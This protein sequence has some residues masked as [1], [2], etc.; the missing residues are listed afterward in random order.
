MANEDIKAQP[1]FKERETEVDTLE[2]AEK[3]GIQIAKI[4]KI[5]KE[6]NS[7]P[8]DPAQNFLHDY[9][10]AHK[11]RP[12]YCAF[13]ATDLR[14]FTQLSYEKNAKDIAAI[15]SIFSNITGSLT[16]IAGG[17]VLKFLGDGVISFF[18]CQKIEDSIKRTLLCS[19]AISRAMHE[20]SDVMHDLGMQKVDYGIACDSGYAIAVKIGSPYSKI[21]YDI[22]GKPI[23]VSMKIQRLAEKG[24]IIVTE[25]I[26]NMV[27]ESNQ[28]N[29][30]MFKNMFKH[31]NIEDK[32]HPSGFIGWMLRSTLFFRS[33]K[34]ENLFYF[35]PKISKKEEK[36]E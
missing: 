23:N 13:L 5:K 30:N 10:N 9:W 2:K 20:I 3:V 6:I 36:E 27:N 1:F 29:L 14:G 12:F 25:N 8:N 28:K 19:Y 15:I 16:E 18:P 26:V 17:H 11:S 21:H 34:P 22:I 4:A 7:P 33:R 32:R 31:F 24:N 35:M